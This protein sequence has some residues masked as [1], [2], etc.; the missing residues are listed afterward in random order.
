MKLNHRFYEYYEK[1]INF[2][3]IVE[4]PNEIKEQLQQFTNM[5]LP[6]TKYMIIDRFEP[7]VKTKKRSTGISKLPHSSDLAALAEQIGGLPQVRIKKTVLEINPLHI[8]KAFKLL[9]RTFLS[10]VAPSENEWASLQLGDFREQMVGAAN[11]LTTLLLSIRSLG[12]RQSK[13]CLV[14]LLTIITIYRAFKVKSIA[15]ESTIIAPYNGRTPIQEVI[16]KHFTDENIDQFLDRF[17]KKDQLKDFDSLFIYSGN[18]SSP[19]GGHSS[20]NYLADAAAVKKDEKLYNA[21]MGMAGHF[22]FGSQ[23]KKIV[24]ILMVNIWNQE[25]TEDKIHS[26]LVT[27]TAPGGKARIIAVADWLSQ[28]ALSA[29]HKT[30]FRLLEMI[31]ADKTY[32][33]KSG[34]EIFLP[35]AACYHSIDL[36]AATDRVPRL[37]Q[38]RLIERIFTRLGM[39]GLEISKYW[40]DIVDREYSTKNSQLEKVSPTLRYAVGQGMGLFSSWSSMALVHHFIVN[41]ICGCPFAS[42][43]LVGD[44]LLMRDSESAFTQYVDFMDQIGVRVNL[45][46][47]LISTEAPHSAEFARNFVIDGQRIIPLPTGSILAWLDGKIGVLEVFCAFAPVMSL[48]SITALLEY[49]KIKDA[50]LL[51]DIA[52]F[53]IRDKIMNYQQAFDLLQSLKVRLILTQKHIEGIIK[54]TS[55]RISTPMRVQLSSL[56]HALESQCTIRQEKDLEKLSELALDFSVLKFAGQEIEDYSQTMHDRINDAKY[57][58]YDHDFSISTVSKREHRLIKDL[59]ITLETSDKTLRAGSKRIR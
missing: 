9:E 25:Y 2:F 3:F 42:Y 55:E 48:I 8:T 30:Q 45:S 14:H 11:S 40:L 27:F 21:I 53:L 10:K 20:L 33:H 1:L 4:L 24:E 19:N 12:Q 15:D 32:D 18:A 16:E 13:L 35:D 26:R 29:I 38:Q 22:K 34:M 17:M 46:K 36:S 49:F 7:S 56:T 59:L 47:T 54:V 57:I 37:I 39:N 5:L 50:L 43:V 44:D 58:Q 51:I 23:F 28:T 41:Q 6:V 31:P 52:Y